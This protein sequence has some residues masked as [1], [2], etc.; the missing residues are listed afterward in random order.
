MATYEMQ[1]SNLPNKE[2]KRVLF[3][4]MRLSG[5]D[6]LEDIAR[7]VCRYSTFSPAE[8]RGVMLALTEEIARSMAEGRS[9]K[10][11]GLGTFS[12]VLGLRPGFERETG[13]A[14]GTRRNATAICVKG[15][16][17][18]ADKSLVRLT[19]VNCHLE[20]SP[21]KFRR[22]SN[23]YTPEQRLK[24]AQDYLSTHAFMTVSIYQALTGLLHSSAVR[25][26][27][28]W[29]AQEDSGIDRQGRGTHRVYVKKK[30]E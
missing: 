19:A 9:V 12:P 7:M 18:R 16:N 27:R 28:R 1:E 4:R 20:R 23:R 30:V 22:S 17:F 2:D 29:A 21:Q 3:P 6:T 11:D 26:L 13:E 25:E 8:V 15:V 14:N 5:Q 24:L 10:I